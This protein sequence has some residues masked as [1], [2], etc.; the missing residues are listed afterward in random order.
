[1]EIVLFFED[2]E[3]ELQNAYLLKTELEKRNHNLYIVNPQ[4]MNNISREKFDFVPD[5]ILVPYLYEEYHLELFKDLFEGKITRIVNLQYEQ[6]LSSNKKQLETQTPDGLNRNAIHLCWGKKWQSFLIENGLKEEN[7]PVVGSL[8]VDM[9]RDRFSSFYKTKLEISKEYNLNKDKKWILFISSFGMINLTQMR[10][11]FYVE[12]HGKD[13]VDNRVKVEE[14]TKKI[15]INWTIKYIT[16]NDCEFIYR[17]HIS[18][19]IDKNLL[20]LEE[21]YENFHI[22]K[23][24]SVKSWIKVCDKIHTWYSTTIVDIYFMKK[25]CSIIRPIDLPDFMHNDILNTGNFTR[26][27]ESFCRFN[28][29]DVT[30][31]PMD[32]QIILDYFDLDEE[33]YAYEKICDLLEDIVKRDVHMEFYEEE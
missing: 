16:E 9:D 6:I 27:Y 30:E 3:R 18:E 21:K 2:L 23:Q 8:N 13:F 5:I 32:E 7:I 33:K 12:R 11:D 17:P 4:I 26:D 28:N 22:I 29:E 20:E 15:L 24:D 19:A 1:M 31:F 14:E 10:Y 25:T